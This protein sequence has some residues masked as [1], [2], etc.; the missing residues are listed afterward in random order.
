MAAR[1]P[2]IASDI[3][4]NRDLV[5]PEVTGLHLP[6]RGRGG[7]PQADESAG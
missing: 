4:G 1:V 3:P 7:A 2:V 5:L 6:R